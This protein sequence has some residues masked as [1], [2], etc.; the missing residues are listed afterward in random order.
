M[1]KYMFII[2]LF[3]L[4]SAIL[5]SCCDPLLDATFPATVAEKNIIEDEHLKTTYEVVFT[6]GNDC[7]TAW[8]VSKE[9]FDSLTEGQV[10]DIT[11][12]YCV[13][14]DCFEGE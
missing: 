6:Y 3:V 5:S 7:S 8:S 2:V 11:M 12:A 9:Y 13:Y 10:V 1:K 4:A 14:Q